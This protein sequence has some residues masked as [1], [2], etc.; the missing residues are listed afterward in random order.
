MSESLQGLPWPR[1]TVAYH[2]TTAM[3]AV[4]EQGLKPRAEVERHATGAGPDISISFT[5]DPRVAYAICI[6]LRTLA[7]AARGEL[8]FGDM[9]IQ[10]RKIA[11]V[12]SRTANKGW[13]PE[14]IERYDNGWLYVHRGMGFPRVPFGVDLKSEDQL[15]QVL[16]ADP[17]ADLEE[18][19]AD[20]RA[21][22]PY[23]VEGWV[24]REPMLELLDE[25]GDETM[26]T[27][28]RYRGWV[29]E[30]YDMLLAMGEGNNE[31]Y[32]PVFMS[33]S[34]EPLARQDIDE[35]G[36]VAAE[37]DAEYVCA[38]WREATRDLAF[39]E[40]ELREHKLHPIG[41]SDWTHLCQQVLERKAKGDKPFRWSGYYMPFDAPD[42]S[43]TV[44]YLGSGMAE[45]RVFNSGVIHNLREFRAMNGVLSD[46]HD[47]WETVSVTRR[48]QDPVVLD[49]DPIAFPFFRAQ[50][51]GLQRN[52]KI[53]STDPLVAAAANPEEE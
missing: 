26:L 25:W 5:L 38:G 47:E 6:G 50:A 51:L 53:V 49:E 10:G 14:Y 12:G 46:T 2:A 1:K 29:K 22:K 27:S 35:I 42:P 19:Y 40:E 36:V 30:W 16:E 7:L 41:T 24:H 8:L 32:N 21:S 18:H 20:E 33:T 28:R 11:P 39:S 4:M 45:L 44:A 43:Q 9:V 48:G 23:L 3:S 17:D 37:I 34:M 52:P 31:V 13:K 15:E